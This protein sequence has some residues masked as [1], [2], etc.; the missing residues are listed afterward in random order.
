MVYD[1]V[2]SELAISRWAV[3]RWAGYRPVNNG[4]L[5]EKKRQLCVNAEFVYL[6]SAKYRRLLSAT[7]L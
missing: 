4:G 6:T 1:M 7:V 5:V 3:L 2:H